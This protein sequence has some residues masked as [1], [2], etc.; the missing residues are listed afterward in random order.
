MNMQFTRST[1]GENPVVVEGFFAAA[2]EKVFEAWTRPEI[3]VKWFGREPGSLQLAETDLKT[4]GN[5][6]FVFSDNADGSNA[7]Q[8]KYLEI[9]PNEKLVFTWAHVTTDGK[10]KVDATPDSTVEVSFTPK[11]EGTWVHLV[12]SGIRN[13]DARL[14]VGRGWETSFASATRLLAAGST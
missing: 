2:P 9:L 14:G 10:G 12:H 8:G 1:A 3:I 5:W 7:L 13:K 6:R 11:G 4:G